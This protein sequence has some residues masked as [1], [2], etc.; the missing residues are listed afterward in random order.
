MIWRRRD[1]RSGLSR[2]LRASRP[3]PRRE[4]VQAL[5]QRVH[6]AQHRPSARR[7]RLGFAGAL[8]AALLTSL[9]A[10]GGLGY[11]SSTVVHVAS[12]AKQLVKPQGE[13]APADFNAAAAQYGKKVSVCAVTP[14]GKQ[15]TIRISK[16]AVASYLATHPKAYLG[17]CTAGVRGNVCVRVRKGG[18]AAVYVPPKLRKA[19]LRRNAGSHFTLTGKC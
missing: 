1:D 9:A 17:P 14:N 11:A 3:E 6:A 15:H 4:F 19:Y 7:L 5:E 8:T 13:K 18:S 12:A 10:F 2:E 16:N